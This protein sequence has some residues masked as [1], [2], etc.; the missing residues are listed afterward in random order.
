MVVDCFEKRI[1]D[2]E[3][4]IFI[5]EKDVLSFKGLLVIIVIFIDGVI[6]YN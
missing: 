2:L 6:V 4:W 5:G 3:R 1:F